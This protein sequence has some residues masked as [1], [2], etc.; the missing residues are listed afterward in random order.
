MN[1][2]T[3]NNRSQQISTSDTTA[4]TAEGGIARKNRTTEHTMLKESI[5][6][7]TNNGFHTSKNNQSSSSLVSAITLDEE[8]FMSSEV[9]S[10]P[11][12][13]SS[14]NASFDSMPLPPVRGASFSSPFGSSSANPRRHSAEET[15]A[16]ALALNMK[17][18]NRFDMVCRNNTPR[19]Y[20]PL[21]NIRKTR[22]MDRGT[23]DDDILRTKTE[24]ADD[25]F[26][27]KSFPLESGTYLSLSQKKGQIKS[28]LPLEKPMRRDVSGPTMRIVHKANIST[29]SPTLSSNM[30]N[31]SSWSF[32]AE[33][34]A[35]NPFLT[36]PSVVTS[37]QESSPIGASLEP[38]L[39]RTLLLQISKSK[40]M[41]E[42]VTENVASRTNSPGG[43]T[44][45]F[46]IQD[47]SRTS[48]TISSHTRRALRCGLRRPPRHAHGSEDNLE[49]DASADNHSGHK[50]PS[51]K[52]YSS[53][54]SITNKTPPEDDQAMKRLRRHSSPWAVQSP[55]S[56]KKNVDQSPK[57]FSSCND[58]FST[59]RFGE[60]ELF[61]L[62]PTPDIS[63]PSSGIGSSIRMLPASSEEVP[64]GKPLKDCIF[65][66]SSFGSID[67]LPMDDASF[68]ATPTTLRRTSLLRFS[69]SNHE[70]DSLP[71]A[72][73]PRRQDSRTFDLDDATSHTSMDMAPIDFPDLVSNFTSVDESSS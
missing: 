32:L 20:S 56:H 1:N 36:P 30:H 41:E 7:E 45:S 64:L 4:A 53:A 31:A 18:Q 42:T 40:L 14:K 51:M 39:D 72:L 12:N 46:S 62:F 33:D 73:P 35:T 58:N 60:N 2:R 29:T 50:R 8:A 61:A 25:R 9:S 55:N 3:V 28:M 23:H 63:A 15:L 11:Q 66:S 69:S 19:S 37:F 43:P 5:C 13:G 71:M 68:A 57:H 27:S 24:D 48:P 22:R 17:T 44:S 59:E 21:C 65:K 16:S 26:L 6:V 67:R 38:V 49:S 52:A 34:R 47:Q 70:G 10:D 54:G